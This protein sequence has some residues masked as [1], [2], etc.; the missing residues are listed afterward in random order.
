[1]H[2]L[3]RCTLSATEV[4][5]GIVVRRIKVEDILCAP[6]STEI[7]DAYWQN[8]LYQHLARP[9]LIFQATSRWK[10]PAF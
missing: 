7:L 1:M 6:N 5:M 2:A 8:A 10:L 9:S 3:L 4:L